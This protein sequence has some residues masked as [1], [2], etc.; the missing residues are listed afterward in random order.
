LHKKQHKAAR[1]KAEKPHEN[2]EQNSTMSQFERKKQSQPK[3]GKPNDSGA[4]KAPPRLYQGTGVPGF[5]GPGYVPKKK[6]RQ[7][8]ASASSTPEPLV[9]EH[10]IATKLEQSLLEVFR[11]T[12]PASNNFEE[13]KPTLQEVNNALV[14]R[15]FD[16]AFGR[17]EYME[18]Y[19][20][21]WSPSRALGYAQLLTWVCSQRPNDS[22]I[23]QLV[24]NPDHQTAANVVC[25]GGSASEFVAFSSLLRYLRPSEVAG[26]PSTPAAEVSDS[27]EV[28]SI[29]ASDPQSPL[30]RLNLLDTADW[31]SVLSKLDQALKT[32]PILSKYASAAVRTTNASFLRPGIVEHDFKRTDIL[33]SSTDDLRAIIGTT[34]ALLTFMS[35]LNEFYT[36]S[37]SRTTALLKNITEAA[38]KGS[39]LLVVD[40]PKAY[41]ETATVNAKEGEEKRKYPMSLLLDFALVPKRRK[42]INKAEDSDEEAPQDAWVKVIEEANVLNKLDEGL[43]YPASL[44]NKRFQVHLFRRI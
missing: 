7:P 44:E 24:G 8:A 29:S 6:S 4:S 35:T 33:Q 26:K 12:F 13:L 42:E 11:T 18:A 9:L 25:F 40:E 41:S 17:E 37:M 15:D 1:F 43:K 32:A 28:M 27:L 5:K 22:W 19:T 30:L 36:T 16:T 10:A 2:S 14:S 39:L 21:R 3:H 31:T 23:Q 38:P 34:P 20:I